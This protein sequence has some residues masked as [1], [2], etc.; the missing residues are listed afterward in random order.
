MIYKHQFQIAVSNYNDVSKVAITLWHHDG[1]TKP[2]IVTDSEE[3]K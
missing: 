3:A 2:P 1:K